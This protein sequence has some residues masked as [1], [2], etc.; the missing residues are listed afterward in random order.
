MLTLELFAKSMLFLNVIEEHVKLS[1][2]LTLEPFAKLMLILNVI[3]KH[4]KAFHKAH[5]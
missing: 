3:Q 1:T 4:V 2:M 5:T